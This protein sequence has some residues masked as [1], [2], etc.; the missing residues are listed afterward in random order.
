MD[1]R[2]ATKD[3]NYWSLL[4]RVF[5]CFIFRFQSEYCESQTTTNIATNIATYSLIITTFF[6]I[7][8]KMLYRPELEDTA[9]VLYVMAL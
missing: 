4:T 1:I 2:A 5:I 8:K 9:L 6:M 3:R 7:A